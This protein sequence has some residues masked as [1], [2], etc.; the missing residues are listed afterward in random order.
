[1]PFIL[2]K[3]SFANV[4]IY[5]LTEFWTTVPWH[6][7][8]VTNGMSFSNLPQSL[9]RQIAGKFLLNVTSVVEDT[10]LDE[11][12][13]DGYL[14]QQHPSVVALPTRVT[15]RPTTRSQTWTI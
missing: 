9:H 12:L 6:E 4:Y 10:V 5:P 15:T 14:T 3:P 2:T 11:A 1:V 8:D 13:L 7:H